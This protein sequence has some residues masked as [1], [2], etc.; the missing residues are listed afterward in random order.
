[1]NQMILAICLLIIL[2]TLVFA[3]F[4]IFS[5]LLLLLFGAA[6]IALVGV[7]FKPLLNSGSTDS[8][9]GSE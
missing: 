8:D 5:F 3:P 1:M 2:S 6:A 4:G 9:S 7:L